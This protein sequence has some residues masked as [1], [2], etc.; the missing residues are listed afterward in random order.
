MN[1]RLAYTE[2]CEVLKWTLDSCV[3]T[4]E[5]HLVLAQGESALKPPNTAHRFRDSSIQAVV[6]EVEIGPAPN[7]E[8]SIRARIGLARTAGPTTR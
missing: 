8:K 1:Y 3:G 5:N 2:E 4:E 6:F 7:F